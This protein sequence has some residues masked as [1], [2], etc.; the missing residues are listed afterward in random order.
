LVFGNYINIQQKVKKLSL[1]NS[2]TCIVKQNTAI[3]WLDFYNKK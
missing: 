2:L 3:C 1:Y